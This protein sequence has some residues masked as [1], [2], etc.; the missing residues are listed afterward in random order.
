MTG[1]YKP[2]PFDIYQ[3]IILKGTSS[4]CL[5]VTCPSNNYICAAAYTAPNNN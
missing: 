4:N 1:P 2:W 3:G 5:S